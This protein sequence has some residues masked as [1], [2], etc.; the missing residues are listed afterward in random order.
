[1]A[2]REHQKQTHLPWNWTDQ[3]VQEIM[4]KYKH[5]SKA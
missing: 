3:R 5:P 2:R 4:K 1:M